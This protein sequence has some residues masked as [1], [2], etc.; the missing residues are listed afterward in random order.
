ME[1]SIYVGLSGQVALQE[2]MDLIAN[3]VANLNTPGF[4]G[5]N[6]VFKE[7]IS[8]QRRMK[9]DVSLVYDIGQY[10]VTDPGPIKLTGNPLDVA[11]VGPGF[12]GVQTPDGVQYTRAGNFGLS[13]NGELIT[14]TGQRVANQ[15]GGTISIPQEA[16]Y[17]TIDQNGVISTDE[18]PVGNLMVAEF[19]DYQKMEP[20]GNGLYKTD[21]P[22]TP[23]A[24][25]R[26]LQGKIEGS[27][28]QPILE[29]TRMIDVLREYQSVQNIMQTEHQRQQTMIQRLSRN[30]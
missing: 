12:L 21:E 1:N 5:Q 23:A 24:D 26:V 7:F 27:N 19:K 20:A 15:G 28:V 13:A 9:E 2:K 30:S 6:A 29:M 4:R 22:A 16:R 10:E 11:L 8:D 3:N 17:V 14:A 18:G 25:T